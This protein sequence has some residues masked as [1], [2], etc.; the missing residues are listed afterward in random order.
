MTDDWDIVVKK[1]KYVVMQDIVMCLAASVLISCWSGLAVTLPAPGF[2]LN[3][4]PT[5]A[6]CYHHPPSPPIR[7]MI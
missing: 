4:L 6:D 5:T 3:F 1:E 2:C 7:E